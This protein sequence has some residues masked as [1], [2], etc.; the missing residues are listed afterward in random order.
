M[1]VCQYKKGFQILPVL[2]AVMFS[3]GCMSP[4][5]KVIKDIVEYEISPLEKADVLPSEIELSHRQYRVAVSEFDDNGIAGASKTGLPNVMRSRLEKYL[6]NSG[7]TIID[8]ADADK[9]VNELGLMEIRSTNRSGGAAK[10]KVADYVAIGM[11]NSV[12]TSGEFQA[13]K[14]TKNGEIGPQCQFVA[15][16]TG[17]VRIYSLGSNTIIDT[18]DIKGE[19][20]SAVDTRVTSCETTG[21]NMQALVRKAG[22]EAVSAS[23]ADLKNVFSPTGYVVEK[24]IFEKKAL[25]KVTLG[26]GSGLENTDKVMIFSKKR[27]NDPLTNKEVVEKIKIAE[28]VPTDQI[29]DRYSWILVSDEK[30]ASR[31]RMGDYIKAETKEDSSIIKGLEGIK[32]GIFDPMNKI[33]D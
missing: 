27:F 25:F 31:I 26:E 8:R 33:V 18:F 6:A 1:H 15:N 32:R 11:I 9:L 28:G 7:L 3:V 20:S 30:Q 22:E 13:S 2:V 4:G 23:R 17:T 19:A 14:D 12:D 24:R 16:V 21:K 10:T 5:P 29:D